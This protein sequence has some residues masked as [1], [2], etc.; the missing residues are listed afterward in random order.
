[1]CLGMTKG[2]ALP[3]K[4]VLK[5]AA[6]IMA[7]R[8]DGGYQKGVAGFPAWA[9]ML[10]EDS[11]FSG[12]NEPL[13]YERLACQDDATS[14]LIDGRGAAAEFFRKLLEMEDCCKKPGCHLCGSPV[15]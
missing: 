4:E 8:K 12:E 10:S 3:V 14:C 13:L 6:S 1:M 9:K 15:F 7:G 5:T 11:A 2:D